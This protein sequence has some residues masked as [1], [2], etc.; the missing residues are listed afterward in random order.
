MDNTFVSVRRH[1]TATEIGLSAAHLS[2]AAGSINATFSDVMPL[3]FVIGLKHLPSSASPRC[4][5]A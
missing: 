3:V 2:S 5:A 4:G 1:V